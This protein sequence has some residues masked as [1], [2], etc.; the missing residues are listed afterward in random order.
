MYGYQKTS[1]GSLEEVYR[2]TSQE[3]IFRLVFGEYPQTDKTY[4]SPFRKDSIPA[5]YFKWHEG[6]LYFIDWTS[7]TTHRNCIQAVLEYYGLQHVGE[8]I[9]FIEN[10]HDDFIK[11]PEYDPAIS[12]KKKHATTLV[13]IKRAFELRDE[14]YWKRFGITEEQ[15]LADRVYPV[16]AVDIY[17]EKVKRIMF[18]DIAYCYEL[19]LDIYKFYRPLQ[20]SRYKWISNV[21]QN[22]IGNI[23][24]LDFESHTLIITK[25]Y[26]DC[27]VLRN[28]GYESVW[29]QNEGVVPA[30]YLLAFL[31]NKYQHIVILYDNDTAGEQ[32]AV[33]VAASLRRFSDCATVTTVV[34]PIWY[35]KDIS[36]MYCFKGKAF[37]ADF[38]NTTINTKQ[39]LL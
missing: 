37:T 20:K 33:K 3:E 12:P 32:A 21:N 9:E 34:S 7:E 24:D 29:F 28:L 36:E 39:I 14:L 35:I 13:P 18:N 31:V 17:K 25:S 22:T 23:N 19:D 5:C 1:Y 8:V 10:H 4:T 38:L 16:S 27:R 6:K 11:Q 2:N 15:L 26:K 30:D